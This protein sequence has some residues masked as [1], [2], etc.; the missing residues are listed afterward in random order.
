MRSLASLSPHQVVRHSCLIAAAHDVNT[1]TA[2]LHSLI[3]IPPEAM[4]VFAFNSQRL[5]G[6]KSVSI[7]AHP[8][9]AC[10]RRHPLCCLCHEAPHMLT[11]L[12]SRA[13]F[14]FS[15]ALEIMYDAPSC[16]V[17]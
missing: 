15:G 14:I 9:A 5:H 6:V 16:I 2:S 1:H 13:A 4:Q 17:V 11:I 3:A 12:S 7:P 10:G 8:C